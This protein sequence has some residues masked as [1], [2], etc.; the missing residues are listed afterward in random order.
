MPFSSILKIWIFIS[1]SLF[2]LWSAADGKTVQP[3][4]TVGFAQDDMA[5]DWRAAQVFEMQQALQ[6]YP[7]IRFL[8]TNAHGSTA[9]QILDLERLADEV[10]L[11]VTSPRDVVAMTPVISAIHRRG[12]PVVLLTRRILSDDYS[13][14]IGA[15]DREIGRSA[16]RFLIRALKEK[17]EV[18]MLQ[19]VKTTTTAIERREGFLEVIEQYP[20]IK[21]VAQPVANYQRAEA[22]RAMENIIRLEQNFDAIYA[23]SDS[24][25]VGARIAMERAG[26]DPKNKTIIGVDYTP[27]SRKALREGKQSVSFTYPTA[28]RE[29]AE[30]VVAILS[31][32]AVRKEHRVP[33]VKVDRDNVDKIATIFE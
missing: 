22:L 21:V 24:M 5:N 17:G 6:S 28:G 9:R 7:H 32:K 26:I 20:D 25:A 27:E 12:V 10:D 15:D 14:F 2:P 1:V 18:V 13:S 3:R 31:G 11:L 4:Y 29:G 33:F 23:H 8:Y 19:G 16:A 30:V